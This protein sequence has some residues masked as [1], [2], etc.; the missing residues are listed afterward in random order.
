MASL[1]IETSIQLPAWAL[2]RIAKLVQ[3]Y[4]SRHGGTFADAMFSLENEALTVLEGEL[5]AFPK[6]NEL[7]PEDF[8]KR[9]RLGYRTL[10][11]YERGVLILL[12][13][14]AK[15][16][17]PGI[18]INADMHAFIYLKWEALGELLERRL[19]GE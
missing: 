14:D 12:N 10:S 5:I 7:A 4:W 1:N 16:C 19:E 6:L 3:E 13:E 18:T 11:D 2:G 17:L 8:L 9:L 15:Q